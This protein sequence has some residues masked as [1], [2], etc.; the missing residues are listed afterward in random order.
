MFINVTSADKT[1]QLNSHKQI[2][3]EWLCKSNNQTIGASYVTQILLRNV[4]PLA[5]S[6]THQSVQHQ[7]PASP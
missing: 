2:H 3:K 4:T 7:P 5:N 6:Q 1:R